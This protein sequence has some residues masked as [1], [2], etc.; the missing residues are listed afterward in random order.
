MNKRATPQRKTPWLRLSGCL[1]G[2]CSLAAVLRAQESATTE[3]PAPAETAAPQTAAP[4]PPEPPPQALS[5]QQE[6]QKARL[7]RQQMPQ[8]SLE[9]QAAGE[10]FTALWQPDTS[11]K[12][13]GV[14]LMLHDAS[15]TPDWP[16]HLQNLRAHLSQQ[17]WSTLAISLPDPLPSPVPTRPADPVFPS[18]PPPAAEGAQGEAEAKADAPNKDS[19][20]SPE[21]P[22]ASDTP[23]KPAADKPPNP[24]AANSEG[25]DA[26]PETQAVYD[27]AKGY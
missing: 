23:D 18:T 27:W 9:L 21:Q 11:G 24:D 10:T 12:T 13:L 6:A 17:G 22:A 16:S 20:A 7:L 25:A 19:A 14:V 1:L 8:Q 26:L 3:T 15:Q 5:V 2:L 4:A